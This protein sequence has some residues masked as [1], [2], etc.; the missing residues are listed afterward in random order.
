MPVS[1]ERLIAE[2]KVTN[3]LFRKTWSWRD[4]TI[5]YMYIFVII[6]ITIIFD[7][8]M[9]ILW[10]PLWVYSFICVM[11]IAVRI[12]FNIT[13]N[14]E[15][16]DMEDDLMKSILYDIRAE[17]EIYSNDEIKERLLS[18]SYDDRDHTYFGK[19]ESY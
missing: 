15:A 1:I 17:D 11:Y 3:A 5:Q 2:N 13:T 18:N 19:I 4:Y 9:R 6:A 16:A 8:S 14:K 10:V 12:A 7:Y